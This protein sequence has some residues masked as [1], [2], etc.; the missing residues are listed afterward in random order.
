[1]TI[2]QFRIGAVYVATP[3][4]EGQRQRLVIPIGRQGS[5]MQIAFVDNLATVHVTVDTLCGR[6]Y[7]RGNHVDGHYAFSSACEAPA[8]DTARVLDI[9]EAGR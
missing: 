9:L 2:D 7:A 8:S 6:E 5:T 1:M 3:A 4:L